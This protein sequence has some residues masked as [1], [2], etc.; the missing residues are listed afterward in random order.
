MR[1]LRHHR[2]S[3]YGHTR[4]NLVEDSLCNSRIDRER[5]NTLVHYGSIRLAFRSSKAAIIPKPNINT[6]HNLLT[7]IGP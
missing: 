7:Q 4:T 3:L 5:V 1:D 2:T 6:G